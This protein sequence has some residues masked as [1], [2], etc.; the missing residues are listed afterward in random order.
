MLFSLPPSG[1]SLSLSSG[2][3]SPSSGGR[4]SPPSAR[5][6]V[7]LALRLVGG[8]RLEALSSPESPPT[9]A[10]TGLAGFVE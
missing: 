1:S 4:A 6:L 10:S 3:P 9:S 5:L 2:A 8:I 7:C